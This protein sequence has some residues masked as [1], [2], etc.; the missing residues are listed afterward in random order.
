MFEM[1]I[2]MERLLS[3]FYYFYICL[4]FNIQESEDIFKRI[5]LKNQ[6]N[7]KYVSVF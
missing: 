6:K 4:K 7:E 5:S 2:C 1:I 3:N